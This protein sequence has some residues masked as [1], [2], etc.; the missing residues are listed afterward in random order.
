MGR[1]IAAKIHMTD[2]ARRIDRTLGLLVLLLLAAII[3][4]ATVILVL[5]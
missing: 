2:V 4:T 1:F 3:V 5:T